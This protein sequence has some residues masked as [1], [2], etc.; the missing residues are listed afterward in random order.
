[1]TMLLTPVFLPQCMVWDKATLVGCLY[2]DKHLM[3][4]VILTQLILYTGVLS[5][6]W[7]TP[8]DK[9]WTGI[10]RLCSYG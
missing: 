10:I 3:H 2:M 9:Y 7:H 4:V 8:K 1:M 6:L 5:P